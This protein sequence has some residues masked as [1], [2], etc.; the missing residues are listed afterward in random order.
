MLADDLSGA[1]ELAGVALRYG[2]SAEVW[3]ES[4]AEG[5]MPDVVCVDSNTRLV[6]PEEAVRRTKAWL[7]RLSALVDRRWFKK[8][9]SLLRGNPLA[10]LK[11][12]VDVGVGHH[13]IL[14]PANPEL[15]RVIRAGRYYLHGVPLDQTIHANDP[16]H[17][18]R[19]AQVRELLGG[20]RSWLEV[21]DVAT[22]DDLRR[23]AA[24]VTSNTLAAGAAEF[25]Q[26]CLEGAAVSVAAAPSSPLAGSRL[27]ACG[28]PA[29]WA[30]GRRQQL[31]EHGIPTVTAGPDAVAS[32]HRHLSQ[33]GA[34]Q[35]ASGSMT[36]DPD[37]IADQFSQLVVDLVA[38]CRVEYLLLEGGATAAAV[39]QRLG[40]TR[41]VAQ[42][43]L[44]AGTV[45]LREA[46]GLAPRLVVK[47]GSYGWPAAAFSW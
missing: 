4:V 13:V 24:R 36:G 17:P 38:R 47:P 29:A 42:Q 37:D 33:R 2:L 9:D 16:T 23:W 20:A 30:S 41:L 40:W 45:V 34:V 12:L 10:E 43:E 18:R 7:E 6:S 44:A 27:F 15:G 26:A 5:N 11:V 22:R 21:P 3:L 14:C 19:T 35:M 25:F 1:A 31:A 39:I 46:G 28:S 32:A 8:V